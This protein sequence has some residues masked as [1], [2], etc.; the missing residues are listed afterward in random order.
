M[1]KL[2]LISVISFVLLK[3]PLLFGGELVTLSC[4]KDGLLKSFENSQM[5][6]NLGGQ[7]STEEMK[8]GIQKILR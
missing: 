1:F 8:K 6:I 5:Q 3:T 2:C 4:N 7:T